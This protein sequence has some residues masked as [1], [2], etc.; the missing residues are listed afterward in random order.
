MGLGSRGPGLCRAG[1]QKAKV[2]K[3]TKEEK[4]ARMTTAR[5]DILNLQGTLSQWESSFRAGRPVHPAG[6]CLRNVSKNLPDTPSSD[7]CQFEDLFLQ[8]SCFSLNQPT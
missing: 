3:I 6:C 7:V 5:V 2:Q 4:R 1:I 8:L